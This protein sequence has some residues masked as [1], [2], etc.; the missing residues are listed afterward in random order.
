M[1]TGMDSFIIFSH[2]TPRSKNQFS[3]YQ[4]AMLTAMQYATSYPLLA[5][6]KKLPNSGKSGL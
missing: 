3:A 4:H 5:A 2:L 1:P 6:V